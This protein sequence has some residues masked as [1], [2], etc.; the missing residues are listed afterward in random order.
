MSSIVIAGDTSGS[1][2]L[3]A[4]AV[5]G[6][7]VLSLPAVTDTVAGIAATQ[8]LTNKT[9]TSPTLTTPV[10]ST[11]IGVGGATASASG[12][13]ITFPATQSASTNANTLDDYEEGTWTPT[14]T[15]GGASVGITYNTTFTGATYTKIGNRVCISGFLLLTNKG[16]STGS[17]RIAN[18]PFTSESGNTKY[19]GATV[20]GSAFTFANQF[21]AF[22]DP[23]TNLIN[24]HEST[25]AGASSSLTNSDFTNGTEFYFSATYTV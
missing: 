12:A 22:I 21:W 3:Q 8:T 23:N 19:L 15:F 7:S 4:P 24:I 18:L 11:T 17:A 20:G 14:V 25:E 13:G 6:S 1:V 10:A 16:S 9:L 5:A 2:T